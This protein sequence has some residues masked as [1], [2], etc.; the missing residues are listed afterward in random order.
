[1]NPKNILSRTMSYVLP[2]AVTLGSVQVPMTAKAQ[3][4]E[5]PPQYVLLA[6]DGSYRNSTWQ[7]LRKFTKEHKNQGID[8]RFTFFINPVYL[9]DRTS[10][11]IYNSQTGKYDNVYNP[12]GGNHGSAIGWGD[13]TADITERIDNMNGAYR[14]GHEIGSHAVG[15]FDGS[16]WSASDWDYELR[17]FYYILDNVFALNKIKPKTEKGLDF[18]K[19]IE[20]FRA[21]V[22][23][24]SVGM[25]QVL[26]NFGIKYDTSQQDPGMNYWPER[27]REGTWN[28]PLA[29]VAIPGTAKKYP[30]MDYNFCANDSLELLRRNPD[31]ISYKGADPMTGKILSNAGKRDCLPVVP[32]EEKEFIKE[33]TIGAYMAYFNNNY[34]GS[35]AP[36]SIGHHFSPWMSGAYFDAMMEI[37][38]TVCQKPEVKCV[39]YSELRQFMESTPTSLM[40]AYRQGAFAKLARP[41]AAREEVTLDVTAKL[42]KKG[43]DL[44]VLVS[45]RDAAAKGLRTVL[46]V[47]DKELSRRKISMKEIRGMADLGSQVQISAIV[48]DRQG[49][50]VQSTT[51][52]IEA[53]GTENEKFMNESLESQF[54]K[55]D[56]PG[57]HEGAN[58]EQ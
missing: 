21:P 28:F 42:V 15:H 20:G 37:A 7:Y 56:L 47:N 17:Q 31:L 11:K 18:R 35:R 38:N 57:A 14:E 29:R 45:G 49:T 5:R 40:N 13:N 30:T 16:K 3:T 9:L 51:H 25:Y 55:G 26:P 44:R 6:F 1:M 34:Y 53:L 4:V 12:P 24:Y 48:L 41:K 46:Y 36:I 54:Q 32:D 10:N 22:L 39:T 50:E 19:S 58:A 43:D 23:G 33:R 2:L 27:R 8:V 52:M